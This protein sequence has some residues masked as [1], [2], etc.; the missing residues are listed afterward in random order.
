MQRE[1]KLSLFLQF[2]YEALCNFKMRISYKTSSKIQ[3]KPS[4]NTTQQL[5]TMI[6][7]IQSRT[8]NQVKEVCSGRKTKPAS[9]FCNII[10]FPH[11]ADAAIQQKFSFPPPTMFMPFSDSNE[12]RSCKQTKEKQAGI[13]I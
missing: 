12:T 6:N 3:Q 5:S 1:L 10:S 7:T 9:I 13:V 11:S 8:V 4:L 2:S